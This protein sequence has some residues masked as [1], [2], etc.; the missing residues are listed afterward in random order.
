MYRARRFPQGRTA[1]GA[2]I[3]RDGVL[4]VTDGEGK[5]FVDN[6][7]RKYTHALLP[8]E[9]PTAIARRFTKEIRRAVLSLD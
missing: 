4:I 2:Y 1:Q 7:G 9:D 6:D 3:V 5:P 8:K